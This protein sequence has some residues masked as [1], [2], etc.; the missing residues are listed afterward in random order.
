MGNYIASNANRFY[1]AVE[2][3][4]GQ[5]APVV[6]SNRFP[7][8]RLQA[9]QALQLGK[10]LDKT[11]TRT[12]L[13]GSKD[14][15]RNTAFD[16][17]TYLT[18]WSGTQEPAYGPLFHAGLGAPAQLSAGLTVA[19]VQQPTQ[20]STN[21]AHGLSIGSAVAY[22]N[23]I[24]FVV[25]VPDPS[26]LVINA[27]FSS[28]P[29][30]NAALAPTAT[31]RL[32]VN[33]PSVTLYDYWDPTAAVSRVVTGAAVDTIQLSVNGDFHEFLFNG[34]AADLIDSSSF[35]QGTAGLASFPSEPALSTFDYS[36]VPG[37]LG[38]V[39]LGSPANQFFTLTQAALEIKNNIEVRNQEF[40]SSF[41]RAIA[42]GER[43]VT[44]AFTLFA[45]DDTQTTALYAA[46]KQRSLISAM[47]QLGYQQGQLLGVFIPNVTPEI[48]NYDDGETRLQWQFQ[49]NRAQGISEDE[50]YIAF[51]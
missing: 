31:Y 6:A 4:F 18:S 37:H 26:T 33:L 23:E 49:N 9:H 34:P 1:V 22:N 5:A 14:S 7:A 51:A 20:F 15:R 48:P 2:A 11:G 47:L 45:Q 16:V 36:I 44:S 10:R 29:T 39:W 27:P 17:R 42:P 25:S 21:A 13:G 30:A 46:A 28:S 32:S 41:P 8:L 35:V 40:G 19:T 24:R 12:F 50:I 3:S 43:Q 38:E